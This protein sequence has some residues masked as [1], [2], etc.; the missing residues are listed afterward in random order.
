MPHIRHILLVAF[1][2]ICQTSKIAAYTLIRPETPM[3]FTLIEG[4]DASSE[5]V[6]TQVSV[7]PRML[8]LPP[9]NL[10]K[11]FKKQIHKSKVTA[12]LLINREGK[13]AQIEIISY[14]DLRHVE[15]VVE[16]MKHARFSSGKV[17]GV[18]VACWVTQPFVYALSDDDLVHLYGKVYDRKKVDQD[19]KALFMPELS[20]PAGKWGAP[21][22]GQVQVGFS[23]LPNGDVGAIDIRESDHHQ[24]SGAVIDFLDQCRFQPAEKDGKKVSVWWVTSFTFTSETSV[25][26]SASQP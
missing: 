15:A 12:K 25:S 20:N 1:A 17:D 8:Q 16:S 21:E 23:V 14:I 7:M 19:A 5:N 2:L 22:N 18:D 10:P 9:L 26:T 13:V 3:I 6:A 4:W 24:F 11:D